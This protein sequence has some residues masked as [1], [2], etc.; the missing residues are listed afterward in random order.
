MAAGEKCVVPFY[1]YLRY[2]R[3]IAGYEKPALRE[4]AALIRFFLRCLRFL[5]RFCDFFSGC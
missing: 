3:C 5:P 2:P 4:T 1:Q